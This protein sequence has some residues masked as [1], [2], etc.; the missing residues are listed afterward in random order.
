MINLNKKQEKMVNEIVGAYGSDWDI[1]IK[2]E[3][4]V[5]FNIN[6]YDS[7]MIPLAIMDNES[8]NIARYLEGQPIG[9]YRVIAVNKYSNLVKLDSYFKKDIGDY[10]LLLQ[11]ESCKGCFKSVKTAPKGTFYK[12]F[13]ESVNNCYYEDFNSIID[14]TY[15]NDFYHFSHIYYL[16]NRDFTLGSICIC[17]KKTLIEL[18]EKYSS[19]LV[20]LPA[21]IH[22]FIVLP[23]NLI[24]YNTYDYFKIMDEINQLNNHVDILSYKVF[25]FH[26]SSG[27]IVLL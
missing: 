15:P 26:R 23:K 24:D 18:S 1:S 7:L 4:L 14:N 8:F 5:M 27:K 11:Q 17:C 22:G 19:D 3:Q 2:N 6:N 16:S 21:N 13:I 10:Y 9:K 25:C 20:L 12:A